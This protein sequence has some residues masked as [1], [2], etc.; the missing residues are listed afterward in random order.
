MS[1]N[2]LFVRNL[3]L[4]VIVSGL[5]VGAALWTYDRYVRVPQTV[6]FAVVD[7]SDIYRLKTTKLVEDMLKAGE[8]KEARDAVKTS[9][10]KFGDEVDRLTALVAADCNC[11]VLARPAVV[12][13]ASVPDYT[14]AL[15]RKLGL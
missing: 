1:V 11:V 13:G 12:A 7:V 14:D 4:N 3:A 6:R 8:G 9:A 2:T 15:K 5:V 10:D